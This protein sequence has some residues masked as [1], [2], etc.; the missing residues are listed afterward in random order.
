MSTFEIVNAL[1]EHIPQLCAIGAECGLSPWTPEGYE[2]EMLRTDSIILM[3]EDSEGRIAGFI[4]GRANPDV[5]SH[6]DAIAEIFNIGTRPSFRK[7]GV[8]SMLLNR[9][10][11][12]CSSRG[13]IQVWLEVR[14]SNSDAKAFYSSRGF[15]KSSVR[16]N[17]YTAPVEDA[18]VMYLGLGRYHSQQNHKDA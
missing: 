16:S 8:G 7:G 6:V 11:K 17:F 14:V 18:E 1:P 4:L 15:L 13:V 2:S 12:V 3:A 9:F 5:S 10:L